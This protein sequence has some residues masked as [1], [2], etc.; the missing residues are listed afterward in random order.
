MPI[1]RPQLRAPL[2]TAG[3]SLGTYLACNRSASES[4]K[5][6]AIMRPLDILRSINPS[7]AEPVCICVPMLGSDGKLIPQPSPDCLIA[8]HTQLAIELILAAQGRVRL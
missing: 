6:T 5:E 4:P 7:A 3:S 2:A 1:I 8:E